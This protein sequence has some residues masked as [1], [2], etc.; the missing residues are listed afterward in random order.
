MCSTTASP[1]SVEHRRQLLLRQVVRAGRD[2]HD[3]VPGL[4]LHDVGQPRS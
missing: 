2:V 3:A 1:N 4:H